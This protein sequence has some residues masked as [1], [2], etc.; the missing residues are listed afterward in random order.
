MK[1]NQQLVVRALRILGVVGTG[2]EPS[3]ENVQ[4]IGELVEP[5]FARLEALDIAQAPAVDQ[6][7]D[8]AF[9]P[10]AILLAQEAAIDF[11]AARD[12]GAAVRATDDLKMLSREA[13]V[14]PFLSTDIAIPHGWRRYPRSL[15]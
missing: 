4:T 3:A 6:I 15:W 7:P 10:F 8:D 9:E 14:S 2:Q 12:E 13:A 5:M 1:T 11:G